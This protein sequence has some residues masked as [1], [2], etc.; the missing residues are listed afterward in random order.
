MSYG[1]REIAAGH[2][3]ISKPL[4]RV[5]PEVHFNSGRLVVEMG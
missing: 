4:K 1:S 3:K 5:D 2:F